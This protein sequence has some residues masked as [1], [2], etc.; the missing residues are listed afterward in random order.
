[1]KRL[2]GCGLEIISPAY[3]LIFFSFKWYFMNSLYICNEMEHTVPFQ[4]ILN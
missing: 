2:N 3:E 1:M 4:D